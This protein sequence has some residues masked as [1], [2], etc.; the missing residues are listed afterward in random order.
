VFGFVSA[1]RS[2]NAKININN[3]Q[4]RVG[5]CIVGA[6]LDIYIYLECNSY[7]SCEFIFILVVIAMSH[8]NREFT[9]VINPIVGSIVY[10]AKVHSN[11]K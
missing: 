8:I 9:Q 11:L 5:R 1:G 10:A 3:V 6:T 2:V 7:E 4:S